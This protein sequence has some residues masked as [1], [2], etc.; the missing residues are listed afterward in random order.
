[1]HN[2]ALKSSSKIT[3]A[4]KALL[5][6]FENNHLPLSELELRTK[7]AGMGVD[8]NKTT[9]YRQLS[10]LKECGSIREVNFGDGKKRFE[11]HVDHHHHL[12]CTNCK[13]VDEIRIENDMSQIEKKIIRNKKF[14]IS[15]H[16][17]EFF[18]LCN[19]CVQ[20]T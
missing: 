19:T 2:E 5:T 17:L 6:I 14:V 8:V 3:K 11:L 15:G 12:V 1:M 9:I 16:S 7:L 13:K 4:R 18:G 20:C 10:H